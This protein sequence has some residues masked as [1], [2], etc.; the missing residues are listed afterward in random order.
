MEV[1]HFY[2]SDIDFINYLEKGTCTGLP[3][4]YIMF[5]NYLLDS[6][7]S[8][9]EKMLEVYSKSNS[10]YSIEITYSILSRLLNKFL[11]AKDIRECNPNLFS[12][13]ITEL[14]VKHKLFFKRD[15][16]NHSA[17]E[18]L[19]LSKQNIEYFSIELYSCYNPY[20]Y[21]LANT[22]TNRLKSYIN[23]CPVTDMDYSD[24][25]DIINYISLVITLVEK[26]ETDYNLL[27]DGHYKLYTIVL[28]IMLQLCKLYSRFLNNP[29]Y[30]LEC[31]YSFSKNKLSTLIYDI[32]N[33]VKTLTDTNLFFNK[34]V[35]DIETHLD[36]N[37]LDDTYISLISLLAND[38][39]NASPLTYSKIMNKLKDI[40]LDTKYSIYDKIKFILNGPY[41][42]FAKSA[43]SLCTIYRDIEKYNEYSGFSEKYIVRE[44]IVEILNHYIVDLKQIDNKE[45]IYITVA[46]H[47]VLLLEKVVKIKGLYDNKYFQ[48]PLKHSQNILL[49][50]STIANHMNM[51]WEHYNVLY[52]IYS[53]GETDNPIVIA[54][55]VET[56][57]NIIK[58]CVDGRLYIYLNMFTDLDSL[59]NVLP[60]ESQKKTEQFIRLFFI[61][62][63]SM[64]Q[65]QHVQE[66]YRK[67]PNFISNKDIETTRTII[68]CLYIESIDY[69]VSEL[70]DK[71]V[72]ILTNDKQIFREDIPDKYI[73]PLLMVPIEN[74]LEC[75]G[76]KTIVDSVSIYNHLV[77]SET[78]PFTNLPL[79]KDELVTHNKQQ[80]VLD[81]LEIFIKEFSEWKAIHKIS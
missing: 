33:S 66:Y 78:D 52:H 42:I 70:L 77:F 15:G 47:M 62:L 29:N 80:D 16:K 45:D 11:N 41:T 81:R 19:M 76:S 73:D 27:L 44:K 74:P 3:D 30:M 48:N 39:S 63:E 55:A 13:N 24:I 54:K 75:P 4:D 61:N 18:T 59:N 12:E 20:Y 40:L 5:Q 60:R 9:H 67:H 25:V 58:N 1:D 35:R 7:G 71:L 37:C 53:I 10:N 26:K 28:D 8:S 79:T 57:Y 50:L 36:N 49:S 34:L 69:K 14:L 51:I 72:N 6:S 22:Y 2:K 17:F 32:E 43:N 64:L 65:N 31:G 68:G 21:A 38:I 23:N 46:N 56:N